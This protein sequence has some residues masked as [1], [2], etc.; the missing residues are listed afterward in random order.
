[1]PYKLQITQF[2]ENGNYKDELKEYKE[3]SRYNGYDD[4]PQPTKIIEER[5]LEVDITD[6]EWEAIKKEVLKVI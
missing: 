2:T 4:R 3:I 5:K 1:M 6:T